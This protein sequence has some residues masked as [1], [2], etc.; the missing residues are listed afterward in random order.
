MI[1]KLKKLFPPGSDIVIIELLI[2]ICINHMIFWF[3][4]NSLPFNITKTDIIILS[5]YLYSITLN[6]PFLI[7]LHMSKTIT[8]LL[9]L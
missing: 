8:I 1:Y 6:H 5:R 7:S 9:L 3:S 4:C 2:A